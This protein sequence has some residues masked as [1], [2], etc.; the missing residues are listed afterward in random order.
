MASAFDDG[1]PLDAAKLQDLQTRIVELEA[2]NL[3]DN[4]GLNTG[5]STLGAY[6]VVGNKVSNVKLV[7]G[8]SVSFNIEWTLPS[9]PV[10]VVLTPA[11][12]SGISNLMSYAVDAQSFSRTGCRAH[13][14][15]EKIGP[16][17]QSMN[18]FWIAVYQ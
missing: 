9:N 7:P 13:V 11:K 1:T 16:K 2:K 8:K 6:K 12:Q 17:D 4:S 10:S 5:N 15:L 3:T 18:F 14:F